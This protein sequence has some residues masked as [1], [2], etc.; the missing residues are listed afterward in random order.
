MLDSKKKLINLLEMTT[1]DKLQEVIMLLLKYDKILT[2]IKIS[3]EQGVDTKKVIH[4]IDA[5]RLK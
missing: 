2:N 5:K 1:N 4:Y 3:L